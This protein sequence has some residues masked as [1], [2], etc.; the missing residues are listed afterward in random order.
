RSVKSAESARGFLAQSSAALFI[1][2]ASIVNTELSTC[3]S[4]YCSKLILLNLFP[5]STLEKCAGAVRAQ[6]AKCTQFKTA[7][8][9]INK[10]SFR[11]SAPF[12]YTRPLPCQRSA[13]FHQNRAQKYFYLLQSLQA[14][15]ISAAIP[16]HS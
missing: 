3:E 10:I 5:N 2:V 9:T 4:G 7:I 16:F 8:V 14:Y 13:L 11:I 1:L 12:I 15:H 6:S